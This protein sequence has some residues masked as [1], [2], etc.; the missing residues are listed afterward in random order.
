MNKHF[1][2]ESQFIDTYNALKEYLPSRVFDNIRQIL[3]GPLT[4]EQ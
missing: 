2:K 1:D 3:Y 4:P